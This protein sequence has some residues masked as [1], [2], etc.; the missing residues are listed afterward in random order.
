MK[1]FKENLLLK[2]SRKGSEASRQEHGTLFFDEIGSIFIIF[3]TFSLILAFACYAKL[4]TIKLSVNN[5]TKEYLYQM[6][7][8]GYLS[9]DLQDNMRE[10]LNKMNIHTEDDCFT[11]TSHGATNQ[12][13][14]GEKITLVCDVFFENPLY[15]YLSSKEH[16]DEHGILF[17]IDIP[18][19]NKYIYYTVEMLS[20]SKW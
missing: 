19:S 10:D 6:E 13:R 12:A 5:I 16:P 3:L 18:E 9:A 7:Q 8:Y 4:I 2:L 17:T 1:K 20:T 15:T 11:G 14:Y